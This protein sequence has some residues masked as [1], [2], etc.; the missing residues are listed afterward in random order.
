[1]ASEV[2]H[3]EFD[4]VIAGGGAAGIGLAA[5]LKIEIDHLR[6]PLLNPRKNIF[7]SL[8]GL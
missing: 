3:N 1:M 8:L 4:I 5:S 7:I 2:T 6:L